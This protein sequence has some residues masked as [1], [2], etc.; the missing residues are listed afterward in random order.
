[1]IVGMIK[2]ISVTAFNLLNGSSA[3]IVISYLVAGLLHDVVSPVRLQ[4]GLGNTKISSLIKTTLIATIVPICSC[5]SVPLGIS[6]YYSGA[7]LGPVL[8]YLASSPF[9]N[10]AALL[11]SLGLLGPKITLINAIAGLILPIII[12]IIGNKF[13]KDELFLPGLDKEI[14]R[15]NLEESDKRPLLEKFRS[16]LIWVK[17]D[18]ALTLSKYTVLGMLLGAFILV[19]FP[20]AF[21]DKYLGNPSMLSLFTISIIGA[22]MY[23]CAV[24]HIPFIA[25][26]IA[27]GA[28]PGIA[29]TYLMSGAATNVPEIYSIYKMIGKK[30]T[31][32]F[33][34]II[35]AYSF[36]VGYITNKI[37]M[38][39]F[40]PVNNFQLA[41]KG[42]A[43]SGVFNYH[44]PEIF[45]Y[46][47]SIIIL[48]FF[49]KSIIP[50]IKETVLNIKNKMQ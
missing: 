10:P 11:L 1:M 45:S 44:P 24:G 26:L 23:V 3:W 34:G 12:G 6:L 27:A 29:V 43:I 20:D 38:P 46:I 16:G 42:I 19:A 32:M 41:N 40:E 18:L 8:A 50:K 2:E 17:N 36:L 5:G 9:L 28:S 14:Q 48:I 21:I 30:A 31:V 49:V 33:T 22:V 35:T 39:G 25:S 15:I 4:K 13:G 47:S 7:Y 37:L